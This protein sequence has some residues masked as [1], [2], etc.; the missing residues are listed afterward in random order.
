MNKIPILDEMNNE[1]RDYFAAQKLGAK[2]ENDN[3]KQKIVPYL[4][5]VEPFSFDDDAH[6][7]CGMEQEE[8]VVNQMRFDDTAGTDSVDGE[9]ERDGL[10]GGVESL[11]G[12]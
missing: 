4:K 12:F 10:L 6:G 3:F 9:F 7:A 2:S 11:E 1:V 8:E 5:L